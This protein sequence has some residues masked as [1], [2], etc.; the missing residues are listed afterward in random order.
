MDGISASPGETLLRI[1]VQIT[2]MHCS[3]CCEAIESAVAPLP[4]VTRCEV[5]SGKAE[6]TFDDAQTPVARVLES[7]RGAGPFDIT[8][9]KK[10]E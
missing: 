2:G 4:G 8:S 9:F 6:L 10:V 1:E 5:R 3:G 7:I